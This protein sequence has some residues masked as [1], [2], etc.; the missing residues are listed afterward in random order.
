ML[1]VL[2]VSSGDVKLMWLSVWLSQS[3]DTYL[4]FYGEKRREKR[5]EEGGHTVR[6]GYNEPGWNEILALANTIV[7]FLKFY[8]VKIN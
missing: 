7:R 1:V 4:I 8:V 6:P 5:W 2:F 3:S